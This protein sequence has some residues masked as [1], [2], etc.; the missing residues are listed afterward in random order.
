MGVSKKEKKRKALGRTEIGGGA[1]VSE[2]EMKV[3]L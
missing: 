2:V 1:Q 3:F